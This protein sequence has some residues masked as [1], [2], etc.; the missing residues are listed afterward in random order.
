MATMTNSTSNSNQTVL[1]T[2]GSGF[3][4][5]HCILQLLEKGYRVRTTVRSLSKKNEVIQ[6][7]KNGGAQ[8]PEDLSFIEADLSSDS[9]WDAAVQG[10]EY[11][12]HVA[13]P[14]ALG[15]PKDENEMIVPAVE[16]TLRVLRASKNA[17]VKR[18]V[19]TS[20]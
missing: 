14:I 13:S 11:V 20:S 10:C 9:N 12:L 15:T 3:V 18:V 8:A 1:V 16:G 5:A 19:I 2:C 4:G 6:M 17:A 7:L